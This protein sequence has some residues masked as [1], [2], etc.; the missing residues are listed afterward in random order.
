MSPANFNLKEKDIIQACQKGDT[1][2][3]RKLVEKYAPM[4]LTICRRYVN[5]SNDAKDVLQETFIKIFKHINTYDSEKGKLQPWLRKIAVNTSLK[6][7]QK[8]KLF[9][10]RNDEL[11]YDQG[12]EPE[13][14]SKLSEDELIKIIRT[15]PDGYREVFNLYVIEGFSHREIGKLLNIEE[16]SSRSNLSRA[17]QYLRI[18]ITEL[19]S[20]QSWQKI[21]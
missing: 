15:L 3:Q 5:Q 13:V 9:Y 2:A 20:L 18:K 19:K 11:K 7:Y 14:Y 12:I 21:V 10:S 6:H 17:R 1:N 8:Q 4:L 16:A